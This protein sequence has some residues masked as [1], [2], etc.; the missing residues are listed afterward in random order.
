MH[1]V[2]EAYKH[3]EKSYSVETAATVEEEGSHNPFFSLQEK[4]DRLKYKVAVPNEVQNCSCPVAN[5]LRN[6]TGSYRHVSI[7]IL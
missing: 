3:F 6:L 4:I 1:Y 5:E 2:S 7:E